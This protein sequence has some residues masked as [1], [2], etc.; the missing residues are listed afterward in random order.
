AF[1]LTAPDGTIYELDAMGQLQHETRP[2]GQSIRYADS[3][4]AGPNGSQSQFLT[5]EN[6][7]LASITSPDGTRVLY[8][9]DAAGNLVGT[10]NLALGGSARDG[11]GTN[12]TVTL[13][14]GPQGGQAIQYDGAPST[15]P[16]TADL[17]AAIR[18]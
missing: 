7:H 11:Y 6:G 9:Y 17:G 1:T 12:G 3:G 8:S 13:A 10:R 14:T 16:I 4:I 15:L 2:G 18:F 5:Y